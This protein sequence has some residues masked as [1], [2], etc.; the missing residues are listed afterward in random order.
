MVPLLTRPGQKCLKIP[1]VK[2]L[3]NAGHCPVVDAR[4]FLLIGGLG[5][6]LD[7]VDAATGLFWTAFVLDTD[8]DLDSFLRLTF[9][10]ASGFLFDGT[11]FNNLEA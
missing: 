5:S 3:G 6:G 10:L 8:A 7:D 4:F 11:D 1:L 9:L 2:L